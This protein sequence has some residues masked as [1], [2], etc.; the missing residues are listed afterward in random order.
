MEMF[1][2][3][4]FIIFDNSDGILGAKLKM[5]KDRPYFVELLH[6]L[7]SMLKLWTFHRLI[8]YLFRMLF[9]Q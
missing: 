5:V 2:I 1:Y 9:L 3:T 7:P 8:G 6:P 4:I